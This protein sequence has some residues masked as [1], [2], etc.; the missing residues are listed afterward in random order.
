LIHFYKRYL[1]MAKNIHG[2]MKRYKGN[3][4][5]HKAADKAAMPMIPS[6]SPCMSI[7]IQA[8][9][10]NMDSFRCAACPGPV[11]QLPSFSTFRHLSL[12]SLHDHRV[13]LEE[14]VQA[15]TLLPNTLTMLVCKLCPAGT[16]TDIYFLSEEELKKH[17]ATHSVFFVKKWRQFSD[18]QCRVCEIVVSEG[19]FN[20]HMADAHPIS[21]FADMDD[22]DTDNVLENNKN[23]DYRIFATDNKTNLLIK[24]ETEENPVGK[25]V[26]VSSSIQESNEEQKLSFKPKTEYHSIDSQMLPPKPK[27][28]LKP[29]DLLLD[30]IKKEVNID[31][32][33]DNRREDVSSKGVKLNV[34]DAHK[35]FMQGIK[36]TVSIK[37]IRNF[38]SEK[39]IRMIRVSINNNAWDG[40]VI[41]IGN[42]SIRACFSKQLGACEENELR[43]HGITKTVSVDDL[44]N[45]FLNEFC[46]IDD[47]S[48]HQS[49]RGKITFR[50]R[51]DA[52][53]WAGKLIVVK[54]AQIQLKKD[55]TTLNY[56]MKC[57]RGTGSGH[58]KKREDLEAQTEKSVGEAGLEK[59]KTDTEVGLEKAKTGL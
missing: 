52:A 11:H 4:K 37:S 40:K 22:L 17:L 51:E 30:Q 25:K 38:F 45:F 8:G 5:L 49:G 24:E 57:M 33:P 55:G 53:A 48:I 42:C 1:K 21:L 27:V 12:H 56:V 58:Q 34:L 32:A 3:Q 35:L 16:D 19:T 43:M 54:E 7:M 23:E 26:K 36:K 39:D 44:H 31:E 46:V 20:N 6:S 10:S 41:K 14:A 59:A 28:R 15:S 50:R 47:V 9:D 29:L 13:T 18:L 2:S